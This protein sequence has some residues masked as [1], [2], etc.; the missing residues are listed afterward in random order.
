MIYQSILLAYEGF[1]R[2][3]ENALF[4]DELESVKELGLE[5]PVALVELLND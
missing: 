2:V 5:I 1:E 3:V 4:L